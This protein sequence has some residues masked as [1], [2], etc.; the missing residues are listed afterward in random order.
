M[1]AVVAS[2]NRAL[3]RGT[4]P[5]GKSSGSEPLSAGLNRVALAPMQKSMTSM[6]LQCSW[7]RPQPPASMAHS[8][9]LLAASTRRRLGWRSAS[10]PA[11]A[12]KSTKGSEKST[13]PQACTAVW[14]ML[15]ASSR[16]ACLKKLSLKVPRV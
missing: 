11:Q 12:E 13:V 4:S 1:E 6:P 10:Q 7:S 3:T 9:R 5:R 8:S 15:T 14:P 16:T 2:L